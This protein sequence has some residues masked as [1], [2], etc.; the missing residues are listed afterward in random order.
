MLSKGTKVVY[1][2]QDW[3]LEHPYTFS[4]FGEVQDATPAQQDP[5]QA[6]HYT[7]TGSNG[8]QVTAR[9]DELTVKLHPCLGVPKPEKEYYHVS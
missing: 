4:F 2:R 9:R 3:L 7:V 5:Y 8:E 6:E 1:A